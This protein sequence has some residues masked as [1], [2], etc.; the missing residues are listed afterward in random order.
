M[1]PAS[2]GSAIEFPD[3]LDLVT[4]HWTVPCTRFATKRSQIRDP[5][6]AEALPREEADLDFRLVEPISMLGGE[7]NLKASQT[8]QPISL[9]K[10]S[11]SDLRQ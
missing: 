6:F 9:S 4:V 1:E 11:V 5:A 10:A 8:L 7:V 2:S 3:D